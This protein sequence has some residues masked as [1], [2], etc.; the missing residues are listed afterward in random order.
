MLSQSP[1][2]WFDE[3]V[4][5]AYRYYDLRMNVV[6]LFTQRKLATNLW[7]ESI[8]WWQ[9]HSIRLRF[10]ESVDQYWFIMGAESSHPQSN[11]SFFKV[12][13]KSE[14][15]ERFKKGHQGEAYLRLGVYAD[16]Q[17]KDVKKDALCKCGH[18]AED[19]DENDDDACLYEV[20]NCKKFKSFQVN[21]LKKKKTI[22]NIE[23]LDEQNVK[24]D[25]LAWNCL[26]VNK[27]SK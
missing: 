6:P 7:H 12:L 8:N 24:N 25:S 14:H 11:I 5:V 10:V 23:F 20:C 16:K 15:Y 3:F 18:A 13:P 4:G 26:N 1:I 22:T 19:H 9:D 17:L 27:Y 2:P 21:L